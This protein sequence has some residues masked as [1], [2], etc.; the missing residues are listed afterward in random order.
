MQTAINDDL[1]I[2]FEK[3]YDSKSSFHYSFLFLDKRQQQAIKTIYAFCREVDDIVDGCNEKSVAMHKISWWQDEVTRIFEAKALH[4]IGKSIQYYLQFFKLEKIWFDEIL[5]GM[6]MDI[7]YHG[8]ASLND[9]N[10]YCHNVAG[11][12]GMLSVSIFNQHPSQ[13]IY[14]F[15][16]KLGTSLQYI[17]II[18]DIGEDARRGRIYLPLDHLSQYNIDEEEILALSC[19]PTQLAACL[20]GFASK[21]H[22]CYRQALELL[23][24]TELVTNKCG[25]IMA[26]LYFHTLTQIHKSNYDVLN[27]RI[28]LTPLKKL[29][30][31][32]KTNYK[33]TRAKFRV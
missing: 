18:R 1:S 10:V 6:L 8:Y 30:I 14:D 16:K 29:W 9:L 22:A 3:T 31:A 5:Q 19:D 33:I 15:A 12:V 7:N 4:P 32:V 27:Q 21:A 23:S 2:C 28:G 25:I 24:D 13:A 20:E 11:T 26:E 17:N